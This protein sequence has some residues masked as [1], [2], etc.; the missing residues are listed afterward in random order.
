MGFGDMTITHRPSTNGHAGS[1]GVPQENPHVG[2][3][4]R[5]ATRSGSRFGVRPRRLLMPALLA[6]GVVLMLRY[7]E[8]TTSG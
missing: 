4:A 7:F 5:S 3:G 2:E 6:L 1:R 8:Q